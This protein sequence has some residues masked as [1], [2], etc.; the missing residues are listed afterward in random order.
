[1]AGENWGRRIVEQELNL[2]TVI[3]DD[4]TAPSMY[5]LRIG[6][7]LSTSGCLDSLVSTVSGSGQII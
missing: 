2:T 3:N 7:T 5:D 1:M 4:G 6:S